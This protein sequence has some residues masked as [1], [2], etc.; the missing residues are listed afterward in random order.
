MISIYVWNGE[1]CRESEV[2]MIIKTRRTLA[3]RV[4]EEVR[5]RHPYQNPALL[6][7]P[8]DGGSEPFLNWVLTQTSADAGQND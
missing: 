3:E 1:R 4:I 2:V 5:N 6:I 7:L 8:V